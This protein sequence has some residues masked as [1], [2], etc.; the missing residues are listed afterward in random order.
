MVRLG[1]F[2]KLYARKKDG[3][4]SVEFALLFIPY[5]FL[6]LGIIELSVM[7]GAASLLEG[8]TGSAARMLRTG[9]IQQSNQDPETMFRQRLC[10]ADIFFVFFRSF[11][12]P[13]TLE[14]D[15]SA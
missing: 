3:T 14:F 13:L 4:T 1:K 9:Q 12:S 15:E 8:A 11:C 10:Q 7:Y 2:L 5:L 6:T